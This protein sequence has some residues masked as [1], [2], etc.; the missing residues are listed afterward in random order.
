MSLSKSQDSQESLPKNNMEYLKPATVG[1]LSRARAA[2]AGIGNFKFSLE[3]PAAAT[4]VGSRALH[5]H[6]GNLVMQTCTFI[7]SN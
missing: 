4:A 7:P 3:P 1:I 5:W 6:V 2:V